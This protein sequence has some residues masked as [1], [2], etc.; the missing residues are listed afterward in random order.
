[1]LSLQMDSWARA[2]SY[3][4]LETYVDGPVTACQKWLRRAIEHQWYDKLE[5]LWLTQNDPTWRE[6]KPFPVAVKHEW[7]QIRTAD[8]YELIRAVAAAYDSGNGY[9]D[10]SK[11]Y[12]MVQKGQATHFDPKELEILQL[13]RTAAI[14][15]FQQKELKVAPTDTS[16]A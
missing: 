7:R 6:G 14:K 4:E 9:V 13:A 12:E 5:R 3:T 1:M 10:K 8:W 11:A 15:Q 16:T 2:T